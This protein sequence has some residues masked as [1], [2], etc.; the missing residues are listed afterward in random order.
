MFSCLILYADDTLFS[1]KEP[2]L[3]LD[4]ICDLVSIFFF[5][6][7]LKTLTNYT[8]QTTGHLFPR[9]REHQHWS[10]GDVLSSDNEVT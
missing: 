1:N 8:T 5:I 4:I 3:T 6:S 2:V 10:K 7:I 9:L